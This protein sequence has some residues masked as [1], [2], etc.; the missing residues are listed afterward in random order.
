MVIRLCPKDVETIGIGSFWG[1]FGGSLE[2]VWRRF[3][4]D[5]NLDQFRDELKST[6]DVVVLSCQ[7]SRRFQILSEAVFEASG[8]ESA[9]KKQAFRLLGCAKIRL[10]NKITHSGIH[11]QSKQKNANIRRAQKPLTFSSCQC[12][13]RFQSLFRND[14]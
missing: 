13:S 9:E 12:S 11:F 10:R 8:E 6:T 7:C 4:N 5:R 14:F 1:G 3:G 2:A